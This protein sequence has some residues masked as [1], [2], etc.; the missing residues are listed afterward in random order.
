MS[1]G[2]W[3]HVDWWVHSPKAFLGFISRF[4]DDSRVQP[5]KVVFLMQG[6][7]DITLEISTQTDRK[8]LD[9]IM[10]LLGLHNE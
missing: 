3:L 2:F 9:K 4:K 8:Q 7:E 1:D 10:K 5:Q 6:G